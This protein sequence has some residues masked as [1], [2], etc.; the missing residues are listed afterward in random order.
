MNPSIETPESVDKIASSRFEICV[1]TPEER[2]SFECVCHRTDD[3]QDRLID[4]SFYERFSPD[5][6]PQGIHHEIELLPGS[7][8]RMPFHFHVNPITNRIFLCWTG[9]LPCV[10][11]AVTVFERWCLGTAFSI[12]TGDDF[13]TFEKKFNGDWETIALELE[14]EFGIKAG[15]V[16]VV[17]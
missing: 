2:I 15:S 11:D 16:T 3:P 1:A 12:V 4:R 7:W 8:E 6:V 17:D 10:E 9:H 5:G 14:K 13:L